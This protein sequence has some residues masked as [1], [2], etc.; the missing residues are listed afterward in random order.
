MPKAINTEEAKQIILKVGLFPMF[1]TYKGSAQKHLVKCSCGEVFELIFST[2]GRRLKADPNYQMFCTPCND[3][4][5]GSKFN[6]EY[7]KDLFSKHGAT[8]THSEPILNEELKNNSP[9]VFRKKVRLQ[10]TCVCGKD[11]WTILD[12]LITRINKDAG[13]LIR[14][15][16][17]AVKEGKSDS[18]AIYME[19]TIIPWFVENGAQPLFSDPLTNRQRLPFICKCGNHYEYNWGGFHANKS[20][21]KCKECQN[22]DRPRGETHGCYDS[23]LSEEDRRKSEYGRGSVLPLWEEM[24]L[25]VYDWKCQITGENSR[26]L[27]V[28]HILPWS[29]HPEERFSFTNGIVILRSLHKEFHDIYGKRKEDT[30]Q[31]FLSFYKEKSGKDLVIPQGVYIELISDYSNLL[32]L[33]KKR[34][35]SEKGIHYVPVFINDVF[36]NKGI[37]TSMIKQRFGLLNKKMNAREMSVCSLPPSGKIVEF[38]NNNHRQG[39]TPSTISI[40]LI[41]EQADIVSLMTFGSPRFNKEYQYELL[42]FCSL[43]DAV[44]NGAAQKLFSY[45]LKTFN[46]SSIISYADLRFSSWTP[47]KTIYHTLGFKH[48]HRSPPNYWYTKEGSIFENR[49]KFQKH[50][51]HD[52]LEKFDPLLSE[53]E[54]MFA[55]G[56]RKVLDCGNHVFVWRKE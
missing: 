4:G 22:K 34:D 42:R 51:L 29:T 7:L 47:E 31:Q 24:M 12:T 53:S 30:S 27:S 33:D 52:L 55:N 20:K 8:F 1:D 21:P 41:N 13:Y 11:D 50:K 45:F 10:Y 36:S 16:S 19:K 48:L 6:F 44:V 46:P 23:T 39:H 49:M 54:N 40:A 15:Q 18:T 43:K 37:I 17:C 38:L 14:C 2:I 56:Y 3:S 5:R 25:R 26:E 35:M 28:H 32:L 9:M